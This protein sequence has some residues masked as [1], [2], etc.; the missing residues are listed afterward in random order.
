MAV[1][2]QIKASLSAHS[3]CCVR[4]AENDMSLA[5]DLN[6]KRDLEK[7]YDYKPTWQHLSD[8][9]LAHTEHNAQLAQIPQRYR[10]LVAQMYVQWY[11]YWLAPHKPNHKWARCAI[12]L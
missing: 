2:F 9:V 5:N 3:S 8:P 4:A 11:V 1:Q 10:P 12:S 6:S 7:Q